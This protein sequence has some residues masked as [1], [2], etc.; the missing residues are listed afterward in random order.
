MVN[1]RNILKNVFIPGGLNSDWNR[2][3]IN[4]RFQF[5]L[6]RWLVNR[7]SHGNLCKQFCRY[8]HRRW[9]DPIPN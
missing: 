9:I 4:N 1:V 2:S 5:L 8:P 6:T 7:R 3:F